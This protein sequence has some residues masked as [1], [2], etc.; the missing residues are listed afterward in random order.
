MPLVLYLPRRAL[1]RRDAI[2][3]LVARL[4]ARAFTRAELEGAFAFKDDELAFARKLAERTNLWVFRVNQRAFAGDFLVVDVSAP[5]PRLRPAVALDLKRG[6]AVREGRPGIQ[7]QRTDRAL[8]ALANAGLVAPSCVPL[9]VVGDARS[10]LA[11]I[12]A[13]LR[14]AR[15]GQLACLGG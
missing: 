1:A 6:R 15:H 12:D 2:R 10:V 14:H 4:D 13:C 9:H 3:M 7:M 11:S 5:S 8:A